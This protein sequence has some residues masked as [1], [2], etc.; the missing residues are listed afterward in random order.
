MT[1]G[2]RDLQFQYNLLNLPAAVTDASGQAVRAEYHYLADGTKISVRD[3]Q[4][5]GFDYRG[6]F[7][8]AVDGIAG[9]AEAE[10]VPF[11]A[12]STL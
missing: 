12:S 6:S 4:D 7:V 9:S 3:A 10:D 11:P 5:E 1:D 8:Y 2:R